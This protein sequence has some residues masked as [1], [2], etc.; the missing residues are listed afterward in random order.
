MVFEI[1]MCSIYSAPY[2]LSSTCS[3]RQIPSTV[4]NLPT[5]FCDYRA[6]VVGIIANNNNPP[7]LNHHLIV[8]EGFEY[9]NDPR[10][11]VVWGLMP[12]VGSPKANRS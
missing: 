12:L 7:P 2:R 11:Y 3:G 6:K 10:S 8:V 1:C 4:V 9:P 5:K